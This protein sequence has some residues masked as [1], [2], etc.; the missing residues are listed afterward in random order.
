MNAQILAAA[1]KATVTLEDLLDLVDNEDLQ[2]AI[3]YLKE[4]ENQ[5][6]DY[7]SLPS[8]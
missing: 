3:E 6:Q 1:R 4:R 7:L 8:T 2:V 5:W